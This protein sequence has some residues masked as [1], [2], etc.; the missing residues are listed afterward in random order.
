MLPN[1]TLPSTKAAVEATVPVL[2]EHAVVWLNHVL[3]AEPAATKRLVPHA[4]RLI[5]LDLADEAA[6]QHSLPRVVCRITPAGLFEWLQG[7][8]SLPPVALHI[9]AGT[10]RARSIVNWI[11]GEPTSVTIEGDSTLATD[12]NWLAENVRWDVADDLAQLV[13]P[14]AAREIT[15]AG[16]FLLGIA[17]QAARVVADLGGGGSS[18]SI[19]R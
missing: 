8:T 7:D 19:V 14:S 5:E 1:L 2:L 12:I 15:R 13:G 16:G 18:G 3:A 10:S 6:A 9:R 4:G 11:A 17:R